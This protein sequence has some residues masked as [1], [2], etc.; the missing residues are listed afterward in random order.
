[1]Y[2]RVQTLTAA[3]AMTFTAKRSRGIVDTAQPA[4][5]HLVIAVRLE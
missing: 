4:S 5:R 3:T 2:R 1:M